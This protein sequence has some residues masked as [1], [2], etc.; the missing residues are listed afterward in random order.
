[1]IRF[2]NIKALFLLL[3]IINL[4]SLIAKEPSNNESPLIVNFN[5]GKEYLNKGRNIEALGYFQAALVHS[6]NNTPALIMAGYACYNMGLYASALQYNINAIDLGNTRQAY[7]NIATIYG[8]LGEDDLCLEALTSIDDEEN[9]NK[10]IA[11]GAIAERQA[12]YND[13]LQYTHTAKSIADKNIIPYYNLS[14]IHADINNIDSALF[15]SN[16]AIS[17]KPDSPLGYDSK[18]SILQKIGRPKQEYLPLCKKIISLYSKDSNNYK[19][20]KTRGETYALLGNEKKKKICLEKSLTILNHLIELYP[21]AYPIISDR[22][23]V[24]AELGDTNAAISDFRRSLDINSV[25]KRTKDGL[26]K[27]LNK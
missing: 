7:S 20:L 14:V 10:L 3:A 24:Y 23:E 6:P 1:M 5:K 26:T 2:L 16:K 17:I 9:L 19:S 18:L 11:L 13:A 8:I 12:K 25:Y 22:A 21:N 4:N 15:Y 27:I